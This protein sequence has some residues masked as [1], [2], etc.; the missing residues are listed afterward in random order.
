MTVVEME[1]MNTTVSEE[2][3]LEVTISISTN[4]RG[5]AS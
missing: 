5:D 1:A 3:I 2:Y 4:V